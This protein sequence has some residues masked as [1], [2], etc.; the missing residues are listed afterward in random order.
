MVPPD[1]RREAF[2]SARYFGALDGLRCASI[3]AVVWHHVGPHGA[4]GPAS[5]GFLGVDLFFAIS[6]FLITT[7]LLR[8]RARAGSVSLPAFYLR[9]TLRIFPAYYVALAL[10][11]IAVKVFE[12]HSPAGVQFIHNLPFFLSYTSNWFV[13]LHS[14]NRVIFYFAWSLATEEQF[15]LL[16]PWAIRFAPGIIAPAL[17]VGGVLATG[18]ANQ[19]GAFG[20]SPD[21]LPW[22]M[23][24]SISAP[25][26]LGCL[27]ALAMHTKTGFRA[28]APLAAR[29]WSAPLAAVL[30]LAAWSSPAVPVLL[31]DVAMVWLVTCA[32]A[33]PVNPLSPLLSNRVVRY[34][35]SISYGMYLVHMLAA[36]SVRRLFP[37]APALGIFA[38]TLGLTIVA[39]AL[40]HRFVERPFLEI[41]DRLAAARPGPARAQSGSSWSAAP[42]P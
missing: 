31:L 30:L 28:L 38:S 10:Y 24:H 36:N 9:R 21:G 16:W 41:K 8:E 1:P 2:A 34:V 17:A 3:V 39:A 12:R 42:P 14:G 26:C 22:K 6:G 19:G 11:F 13:D 32:C 37:A 40:S 23:L 18:L 15:Y 33:R 27:S 4:G 29:A 7:L 25:I 5:R 35:G 20:L